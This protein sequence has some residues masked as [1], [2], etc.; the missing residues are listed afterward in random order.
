MIDFTISKLRTYSYNLQ[1]LLKLLEIEQ[2]I[3]LTLCRTLTRK[4]VSITCQSRRLMRKP[5][6]I[7]SN[8]MNDIDIRNN[9]TQ[10]FQAQ[11]TKFLIT[12]D[13][14]ENQTNKLIIRKQN[15]VDVG[16]VIQ[17]L[18]LLV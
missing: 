16:S 1:E 7:Q 15:W 18:V 12:A 10:K 14:C 4:S 9:S 11:I 2:I 13:C 17:K 8:P 6:N 3:N 5:F